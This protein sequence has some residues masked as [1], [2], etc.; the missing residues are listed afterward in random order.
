MTRLSV[1]L[2]RMAENRRQTVRFVH[3]LKLLAGHEARERGSR[4]EDEVRRLITADPS[5]GGARGLGSIAW[6]LLHVAVFEEGCFG[7]PPRPEL[8]RRFEHG[9]PP[10]VPDGSL[11]E[12]ENDLA[13]C[14]AAL[15]RRAGTWD[16]AMLDTVPAGLPPGGATY[17]ELLESVAWHEP[18]HLGSCNENLR[19]QF[20]EV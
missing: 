9:Q 1:L 16:E 4:P 10:F 14:R 6:H 5:G 18:H 7:V 20:I 17:R 12:I 19:A 15:L 3:Y 13:R 11:A 8:W 2:E